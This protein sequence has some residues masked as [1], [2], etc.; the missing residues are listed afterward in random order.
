MFLLL[1]FLDRRD[2]FTNKNEEFYKP[3]IKKK[4]LKSM[5]FIISFSQQV[6]HSNVTWEEVLTTKFRLWVDKRSRTDNI[7][8]GN[9]RAKVKSRILLQIGKAA[10]I[11]DGDLTYCVFL[12]TVFKMQ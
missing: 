6:E 4:K 8:H 5:A 10:K 11:S 7:L 12:H 9:S 3:S 1:L 2:D